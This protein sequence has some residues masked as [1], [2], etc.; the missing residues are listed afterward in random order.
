[1]DDITIIGLSSP[2]V[3]EIKQQLNSIFDCKDL[4]DAKYIL[5]LE[6]TYTEAGISI[7]Q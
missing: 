6:L 1:V 2:F 3:K 5:G 4:G 7:S